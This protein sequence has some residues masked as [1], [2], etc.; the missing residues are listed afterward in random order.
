[1]AFISTTFVLQ[2]FWKLLSVAHL[3]PLDNGPVLFLVV[4]SMTVVMV[5]PSW[6]FLEQPLNGLKRHFPYQAEGLREARKALF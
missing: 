3:Q 1:M 2:A 4:T 6:K 5:A